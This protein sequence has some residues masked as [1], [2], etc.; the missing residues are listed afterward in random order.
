MHEREIEEA[1]RRH[2]AG[3][4]TYANA[5]YRRILA[6][7]PNHQRALHYLGLLAQQSGH[8]ADA[9]SLVEQAIAIDAR[10]PAI[11]NHLGQIYLTLGR[12]E[13]ALETFRAGVEHAPG[14]VDTL[15]SL[16]NLLRSNGQLAEA[17]R[18]FERALAD[19]HAP[20]FVRYNYARVLVDQRNYD[21]ALAMF[22]EA[23]SADPGQYRAHFDLGLALEQLGRFSE[24]IEHYRAVLAIQP[25][26]VKAIANLLALRDFSPDEEMVDE[27]EAMLSSGAVQPAENAKMHYG[28]GK[29]Y[30]R[31][32]DYAAAFAHFAASNAAQAL[33][34]SAYDADRTNRVYDDA[35]ATYNA[36]HFMRVAGRGSDSMRPIFVV[37][38]P[39]SGTTLTEQILASHPAVFGAG[40]LMDIPRMAAV[41]NPS[42]ADSNDLARMA[43]DYLA[44]I[45]ELAPADAAFVVDKLPM[46]YFHLGLISSLFPR[47]TIIHVSRDPRD[48][49][50]SCFIEMFHIKEQDYTTDL[51]HIAHMMAN[52]ARLM[53]HWNRVLPQP[54]L[55]LS[56]ERLITD[57]ATET[58]RL[59]EHVGLP[60]DDRCLSYFRTERHVNT[61][62]RWQVRQ[63]IYDSSVGRWRN[64]AEQLGSLVEKLGEL[65]LI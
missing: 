33:E 30:D 19:P 16:G 56:Y 41:F 52:K 39:R 29:Y 17:E 35:I 13:D 25:R 49:A 62:S 20:A 11:F 40:E 15:N 44:R 10:D 34:R 24:A 31:I 54:I 4:L 27:A 12:T 58:R 8:S 51:L 37:G 50:L 1:W 3:D 18:I 47:A 28:L 23:I 14:H 45:S 57:Q 2:R 36:A 21:G 55:E 5:V 22:Q 53:A 26:H 60:W 46:N 63:P 9:A 61:P 59:L 32:Q 38:M 48:I 65:G 43:D 7:T 42:T 6:V 64:Y